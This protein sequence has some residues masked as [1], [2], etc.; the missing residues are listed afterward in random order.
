MDVNLK[1]IRPY[2]DT[3]DDGAIQLSFSLPIKNSEKAKEAAKQFVLKLGFKEVSVVHNED[4]GN[5][6]SFF[7]VY[8]KTDISIDTTQIK[9]IE[10]K[11]TIWSRDLCNEKI[12]NYFGR[13][14]VIVGACVGEDA[15][16]VGIDA[17][18]NMKGYAGHYGLERFS[19]IEPFNMGAQVLCENLIKKAIEVDADAILVSQIVT[20]KEIHLK[21]FTRLI[22][23]AQAY[24]IRKKVIIVAGGPRIDNNMAIEL[25]YDAGFG[26]GAFAED[27]ASFVIQEIIRRETGGV[28][29]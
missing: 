17:I 4:L 9:L 5:N 6:F 25:G 19:M 21:N 26:R 18:M 27:V 8:G 29:K 28:D 23:L 14:L 24:N 22:E 11:S 13:K 20:Q 3:L 16:T 2:G 1:N 10:V 15:H 12:Q 7:I